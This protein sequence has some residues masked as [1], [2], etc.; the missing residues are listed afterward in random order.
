MLSWRWCDHCGCSRRRYR[1]RQWCHYLLV[2]PSTSR[3]PLH[4]LRRPGNTTT[5]TFAGNKTFSGNVTVSGTTTLNSNVTVATGKTIRLVGDTTAQRPASPAEGMLYFDTTTKK[6]LV[7]SNGK[8]QADRTDAILVAASNSSQADKDAAD[9]V[10]DGNTG[11]AN[12]G[13]QIQINQALTAGAGK[14]VVLLAGT[15]VADATILVPNNTTLMGVGQGTVI[16]LANLGGTSDN[17]IEN[18]DQTT[19][20][21]VIIRN[22][23][24]DGR[25]DL[26]TTGSHDGI[27]FVHMGDSAADRKGSVVSNVSA[28]RFTKNGI[29]MES[30]ASNTLTGN[31][32]SA[33]S[34]E[35]ILLW[36]S[37]FNTLTG[38]TVRS[39]G[40]S[41]FSFSS[42]SSN[43]VVTNNTAKNNTFYG[44]GFGFSG[45]TTIN[46]NIAQNNGYGGIS[47]TSS[48][49]N[50]VHGN[51]LADNGGGANNN[52]I[53]LSGSDDT[54]I[55]SNAI[56]DSSATSTNYAI[57]ISDSTS[58]TNYLSN[59]TLGGGSI[60]DAGTGTIYAGQQNANGY[61]G[62]KATT[63]RLGIGNVSPAYMLDVSGDI[64]TTTGYRINGTAGL[65]SLTCTGGELLQNA[66][67]A[68]GIVTGGSC[69]AAGGGVTTVGAIDGGT[70]SANGAS[71]SGS[72]IYL[73]AA[74]NTHA[75]LVTTTDPNLCR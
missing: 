15:Y 42:F 29:Y 34:E 11:A 9:Y 41:G 64:N 38:N 35:G 10:A 14:K 28:T 7:Y 51:T 30:S 33:T 54:Q 24:L 26:N 31:D 53:Y 8:W 70:Y 48:W 13:D 71:I 45:T 47:L 40:G 58:D 50:T 43:N 75:G 74:T 49:Q 6:L 63:T 32:V 18:S 19:G 5:Q 27:Y 73:Q 67:I 25:K 46:S 62:F 4:T 52:G 39:S 59:N 2:V 65:S 66:T 23:K 68:G 60:N 22:I 56:T 57:N 44:Y 17:L 3:A 21:G 12:D 55:T 37:S 20:T 16:E 61:F 72:T 1:Q 69:V 36:D